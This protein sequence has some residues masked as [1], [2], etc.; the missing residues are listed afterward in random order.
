MTR[1]VLARKYTVLAAM[2]VAV[3]AG[4]MFAASQPWL[5]FVS[6]AAYVGGTVRRARPGRNSE[7]EHDPG[8][9]VCGHV[10]C[11]PGCRIRVVHEHHRL[12]RVP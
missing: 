9:R 8:I 12:E 2:M 3:I 6:F 10:P 7:P 4:W 1:W 5:V 11:P